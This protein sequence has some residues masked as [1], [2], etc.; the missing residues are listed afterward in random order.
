MKNVMWKKFEKNK[1]FM[2]KYGSLYDF[3]SKIVFLSGKMTKKFWWGIFL[4]KKSRII[5]WKFII[6]WVKYARVRVHEEI[7]WIMTWN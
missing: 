1:L 6:M 7:S 3:S 4:R 2:V 5:F